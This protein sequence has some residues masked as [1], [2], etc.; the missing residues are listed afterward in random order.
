MR[1]FRCPYCCREHDTRRVGPVQV[2]ECST[3]EP[4]EDQ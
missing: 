1:T 2:A 3:V 4:Q